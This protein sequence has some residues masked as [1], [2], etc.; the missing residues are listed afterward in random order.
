[1]RRSSVRRQSARR[2]REQA[3]RR[4]Y[5]AELGD[6]PCALKVFNVCTGMAEAFHELVGA[7]Q[8][9][10]RVDRSNLAPA[11]NRCNSHVEDHPQLAVLH[12][13]KVPQ[14]DAVPGDGGL[15]PA[16]PNR[17]AIRQH[18]AWNGPADG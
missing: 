8:G 11:C 18:T 1:M 5:A 2:R 17:H 4:G 15:V 6:T 12:G 14:R 9:G 16:V 3:V 13:W 7:G 10:S